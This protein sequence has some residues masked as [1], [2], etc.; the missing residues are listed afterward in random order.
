MSYHPNHDPA[1][2]TNGH[3][4]S[5]AHIV[6]AWIVAVLTA[7]YMLPWAIAAT[8]DK[9]N[10]LAI[11]MI[12]LF[13]GWTVVGWAAALIMACGTEARQNVIINSAHQAYGPAGNGHLA[14]EQPGYGQPGYGQPGYGQPGYGQPGYGQPGYGQP[15][16]GQPGYGQPEHR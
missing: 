7:G 10:A 9:T 6:V 11:A 16:Y 15:G 1:V 13:L 2:L 3:S 8:R 12:N 4:S 5:H 14:I